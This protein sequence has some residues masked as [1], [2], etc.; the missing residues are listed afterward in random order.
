MRV[1]VF[2]T[3]LQGWT[4]DIRAKFSSSHPVDKLRIGSNILNQMNMPVASVTCPVYETKL[5]PQMIFL[6]ISLFLG[7]NFKSINWFSRYREISKKKT[8]EICVLRHEF[9]VSI[10]FLRKRQ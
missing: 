3:P 2:L 8:T 7:V 4:K 6:P 5:Q 9:Q 1:E 10:Q